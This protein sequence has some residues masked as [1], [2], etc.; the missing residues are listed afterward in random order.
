M[1]V[2]LIGCGRISRIHMNAYRKLSN[3]KVV[4][5]SD[6]DV[7][8]AKAFANLCKIEK[9]T[10]DYRE[11]FDIK[12]LD[13]VDICT[14]TATHESIVCEAAKAGINVLVEKPMGRNSAE[15][16]RMI[17]EAKKHGTQICVSHNQLF[18]PYVTRLKSIANSKDFNLFAFRT[19]HRENFEWLKAHG[20]AQPWNVLS[21]HGG[22]LWEVGTHLAYLQLNFLTDIREV[23]AIG[24]KAKYAVWDD[25][26]VLLRTSSGRFGIMEISWI[27]QES[28]IFY[29]IISAD[30]RRVQAFLP[31]GHI[32][33]RVQSSP[34]NVVEV[35]QNFLTD[36]K[37]LSRK[38]AK[39]TVDQVKRPTSGHFELISRY[40]DC[41]KKGLPP[42]VTGEDGRNAIRLLECI[43]DSLDKAE[44]VNVNLL[45]D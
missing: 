3:V 4:A 45:K 11:L 19:F 40:I 41:L 26:A 17:T 25:F 18:Y 43:Q 32:V 13:F 30:G 9:F 7:N 5:V 20:L 22:I 1:N 31:H 2:G 16:E 44:P 37:R 29:E 38:W 21:E 39:F 27:A 10:S 42:P 6:V 23:Y 24:T 8:R 35:A 15:C 33:E 12:D 28:E 36:L 34:A 14:P